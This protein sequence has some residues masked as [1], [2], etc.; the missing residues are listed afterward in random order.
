MVSPQCNL[1]HSSNVIYE[2]MEL[3]FGMQQLS[4]K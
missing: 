4:K 2:S 3:I 1:L